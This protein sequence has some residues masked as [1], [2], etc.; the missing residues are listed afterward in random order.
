MP[1]IPEHLNRAFEAEESCE[2]LRIIEE[3]QD[4]DL[5]A[6]QQIAAEVS[7]GVRSRAKAIYALGRW[8]DSGSVQVIASALPTLDEEGI[9]AAVDGLGRL[10]TEE[11]VRAVMQYAEHPSLQVRKFVV[12]ALGRID[13]PDAKSRLKA[14][15]EKDP[16]VH[17][18]NLALKYGGGPKRAKG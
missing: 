3:K 6:L 16:D 9:A 13:Q 2:L 8:G 18:R 1:D 12:R 10:G 15:Q 5:E 4:A 7:L 17:I 14:M 11:A